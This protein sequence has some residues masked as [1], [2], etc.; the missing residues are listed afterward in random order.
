M[1]SGATGQLYGS[2]F[3]WRLDT[4]W[5][6]NLDTPGVSQLKKMADLFAPRKWYALVPDQQH[7]VVTN[8]Y[9]GLSCAAGK[10]IARIGSHHGTAS[11][12]LLRILKFLGIG[13]V[14]SNTC[15]ATAATADG[16]LAIVYLPSIR[17]ITVNMSKLV[18][19]TIARWYDP[20]S[21][22]FTEPVDSPLINSGYHQFRPSGVNKSGDGDWVL[23]LEHL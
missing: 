6:A 1:L 22:E 11:T 13:S 12:R 16:S 21:G 23:V 4:N 5:E 19:P 15:A 7:L 3:S 8:G 9:H 14:G 20:T 10:L 18:G 2:A 17:T